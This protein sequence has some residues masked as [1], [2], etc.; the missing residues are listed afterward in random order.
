[1]HIFGTAIGGFFIHNS[2]VLIMNIFGTV[3]AGFF[4]LNNS[5]VLILHIYKM[6]M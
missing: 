6:A 3:I 2:N 4:I 1:M 5:N